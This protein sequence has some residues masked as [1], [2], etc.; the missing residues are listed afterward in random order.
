M[1]NVASSFNS[2]KARAFYS[3]LARCESEAASLQKKKGKYCTVEQH[4]ES[5]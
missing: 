5:N 1:M 3:V 2:M 4:D